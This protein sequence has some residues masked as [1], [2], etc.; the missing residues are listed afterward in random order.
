MLLPMPQRLIVVIF[1]VSLPQSNHHC[2]LREDDDA[3]RPE[4][5]GMMRNALAPATMPWHK[6]QRNGKMHNAT[7]P[8]NVVAQIAVLPHTQKRYCTMLQHAVQCCGTWHHAAAYRTMPWHKKQLHGTK[9]NTAAHTKN[10]RSRDIANAV[11]KKVSRHNHSTKSSTWRNAE[12]NHGRPWHKAQCC[13]TNHI[14][15]GTKHIAAAQKVAAAH[16]NCCGTKKCAAAQSKMPR[17]IK[18]P[19]GTKIVPHNAADECTR[20]R[21]KNLKPKTPPTTTTAEAAAQVDCFFHS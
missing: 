19:C 15:A 1:Y 16:K 7:A 11:A 3:T 14:A 2:C 5:F 17:H 10:Q 8:K 12:A 18:Q 21:Q 4:T 13:G 20:P 6:K 9:H